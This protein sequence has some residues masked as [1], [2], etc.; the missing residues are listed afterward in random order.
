MKGA[1]TSRGFRDS[2]ILAGWPAAPSWGSGSTGMAIILYPHCCPLPRST[3]PSHP[4]QPAQPALILNPFTAPSPGTNHCLSSSVPMPNAAS[5]MLGWGAGQ[6]QGEGQ[7]EGAGVR[8]SRPLV[9][10]LSAPQAG[11]SLY[12]GRCWVAQTVLQGERAAPP[13]GCVLRRARP[14][15]QRRLG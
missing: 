6:E 3:L 12:R 9:L 10:A 4:S 7:P 8:V 14:G 11:P 1:S 5:A 13:A 2:I 15:K